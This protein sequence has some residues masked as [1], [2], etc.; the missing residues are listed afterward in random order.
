MRLSVVVIRFVGLQGHLTECLVT[1]VAIAMLQKQQTRFSKH[2]EH[3]LKDPP[4]NLRVHSTRYS[5]STPHC[6]TWTICWRRS[7]VTTISTLKDYTP[8][9]TGW[10]RVPRIRSEE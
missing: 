6:P 1:T 10:L 5:S 2:F 8:L 3:S 9:R 4:P 7:L